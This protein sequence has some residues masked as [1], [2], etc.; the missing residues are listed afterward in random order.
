MSPIVPVADVSADVGVGVGDGAP[1]IDLVGAVTTRAPAVLLLED[2]EEIQRL[3]AAMMGVRGSP[4]DVA[5]SLAEARR[6][7]GERHYDILFIDVNLP[8][9]SGLSFIGDRRDEQQVII[10]MTGNDDLA[11]AIQAIRAGAADFISKPFSVGDFLSR[12]DK[13]REEWQVREKVQRYARALETLVRIRSDELFRSS[14]RFEEVCDMTV[15]SLGAALNLKDHETAD[16]CVRV[17]RNSVSL[18]RRLQLSD[19]ELRNL[20][21]GAHLHDVGKI[22]I[23]ESILLKPGELSLEERETMKKH[24]VMGL[25]MLRGIEFLSHS[26]DVVLSHH[27]RYDGGGYPQGLQGTGIPL[28]ARIFSL[29]D[30]LDAMTSRRPY[31]EPLDVST[32]ARELERMA[33]TQ[34][35]P[36]ILEVFLRAPAST[37]LL[38]ETTVRKESTN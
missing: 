38:Q 3:V 16:H 13:A 4:C 22:G 15:A 31:R 37:W 1:G 19:F 23:P 17:S 14:R 32:A 33:G 35:D 20:R 21:W 28:N 24:P 12:F 30:A 11:T 34:F 2:Q 5:G 29:L 7:M 18:G 6:L 10:V 27:E 36:E 8:D 9:G 26:T 25:S